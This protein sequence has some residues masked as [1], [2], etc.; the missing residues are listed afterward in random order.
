MHL[1]MKVNSSSKDNFGQHF[2]TTLQEKGS[3][4]RKTIDTLIYHIFLL[5]KIVPHAGG[6]GARAARR[7]RWPRRMALRTWSP[8]EDPFS[9]ATTSRAADARP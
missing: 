5:L 1:Q 4:F 3:S 9:R 8:R 2:L 7:W 6:N